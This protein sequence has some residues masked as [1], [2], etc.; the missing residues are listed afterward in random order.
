MK[1]RGAGMAG[2]TARFRRIE[3][4][5]EAFIAFYDRWWMIVSFFGRLMAFQIFQLY[6][7]TLISVYRPKVNLEKKK[8]KKTLKKFQDWKLI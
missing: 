6:I 7:C 1:T 4:F 3:L 8:K 5:P 2:V